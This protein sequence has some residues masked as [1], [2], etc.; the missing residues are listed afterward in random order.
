MW[1]NCPNTLTAIIIVHKQ[2]YF[3]I[4]Y[5]EYLAHYEGF[6]IVLST[7]IFRSLTNSEKSIINSRFKKDL[8]LKIH[9][10]KTFFSPT[11]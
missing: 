4:D 9:L 7:V 2:S 8:N 5:G 11:F 10:H 1:Q 3:N 6:S